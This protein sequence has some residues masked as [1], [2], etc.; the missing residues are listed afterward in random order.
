MSCIL[1][2]SGE[3]LDTDALLSSCTLTINSSWIK[4]SPQGIRG[5]THSTSGASFVASE[6]DFDEFN[7]QVDDASEFLRANSAEISHLAE[8][9]GVDQATLD[10][11]VSLYEDSVTRFCYLPPALIRSA[12]VAGLGL[13]VSYYA[14][15]E[16]S[17]DE[18]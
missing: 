15:S 18:G 14:C 6:A 1:R 16:D 8:F 3:S 2:I 11:A 12:A 5:K 9:T 13:E 17:E 4:G 10:F 7:T